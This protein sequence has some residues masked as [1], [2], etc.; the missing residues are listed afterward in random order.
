[1]DG[2]RTEYLVRAYRALGE[3]EGAASIMHLIGD[4]V[5]GCMEAASYMLGKCGLLAEAL[6]EL[7]GEGE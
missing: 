1:M 7:G 5:D 4:D 6:A 3:I 2:K